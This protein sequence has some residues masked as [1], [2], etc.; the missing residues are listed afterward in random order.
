MVVI[1]VHSVNLRNATELHF[2]MVRFMS[3]IQCR[4]F[5]NRQKKKYLGL[6]M[7]FQEPFE[8]CVKAEART[9]VPEVRH[10]DRVRAL[11]GKE[12][13]VCWEEAKWEGRGCEFC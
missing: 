6:I 10:R 7:V 8:T 3:C 1:A 9:H 5:F 2:K 13:C 4:I 11:E 12:S